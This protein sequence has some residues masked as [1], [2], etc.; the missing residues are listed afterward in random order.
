LLII[1]LPLSIEFHS[2]LVFNP[3]SPTVTPLNGRCVSKSLIG[4]TNQF[5]PYSFS[6]IINFAATK[7]KFACFPKFPILNKKKKKTQHL[8]SI[9]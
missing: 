1:K 2:S 4:T 3:I 9:I 5:I 6:S 8:A 7:A